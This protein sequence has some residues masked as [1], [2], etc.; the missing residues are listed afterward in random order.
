MV[1]KARAQIHM[2]DTIIED[3]ELEK[4]L[5]GRQELKESV[6]AY[7]QADKKAKAKIATIV[8]PTPYRVG[9]F[10]ISKQPVAAKSVAFDTE[11]CSRVTIKL[12]GEK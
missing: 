9:R 12:A 4:L 11:E 1:T 3:A 2:D 5:E 6:S 8:M 10:V 7:R